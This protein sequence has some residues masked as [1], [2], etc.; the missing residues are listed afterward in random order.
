[1]VGRYN[2]MVTRVRPVFGWLEASDSHRDIAGPSICAP[3]ERAV[4]ATLRR[5]GRA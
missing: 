4:A 2:S 5:I 1:M 3:F